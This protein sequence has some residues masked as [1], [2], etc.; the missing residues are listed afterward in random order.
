MMALILFAMH[1]TPV[2][3]VD[4][5]SSRFTCAC[6][7][8][9]YLSSLKPEETILVSFC[10]LGWMHGKAGIE[11]LMSCQLH[12]ERPCRHLTVHVRVSMRNIL[13]SEQADVLLL[14][15]KPS[16]SQVHCTLPHKCLFLAVLSLQLASSF[17]HML[18]LHNLTE[19]VNSSQTERAVRLGEVR[20]QS[21]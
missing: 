8:E 7:L 21:S 6:R 10:W 1:R 3:P 5:S 9:K 20:A 2:T 15:A 18:N 12:C 16:H 14:T 19:E 17:S 11:C 4:A 13:S